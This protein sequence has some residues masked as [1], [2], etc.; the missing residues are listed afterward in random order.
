MLKNFCG[1]FSSTK[2]TSLIEVLAA[3]VVV[4]LVIGSAL[5]FFTR[6]M[7]WNQGAAMRTRAVYYGQA[8]IEEIKVC[9]VKIH[10]NI[11][12]DQA[13]LDLNVKAPK[14]ISSRVFISRYDAA[15]H[16][17]QIRVELV[18]TVRE[19]TQQETLMAILQGVE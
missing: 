14:G 4:S 12:G 5:S 10:E 3:L 18:W 2:G 1:L 19:K 9:P 8:L 11:S 17:Y 15:L 7:A 13:A 6:G 16:L